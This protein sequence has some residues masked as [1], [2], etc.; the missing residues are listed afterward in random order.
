MVIVV[1]PRQR[2]ATVYRS[3]TNIIAL[4]EDDVLD[5]V[6]VVPGFKLAVREIFA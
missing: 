3:Q 6:D 2:S 1:N 5:G 4:T